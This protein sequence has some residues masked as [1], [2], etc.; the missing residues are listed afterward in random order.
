MI[1]M[2]ISRKELLI[3][4]W[5]VSMS[6]FIRTSAISLVVVVIFFYL[7]IGF[8]GYLGFIVIGLYG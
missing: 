4:L 7:I 2:E 6:K 5:F 8:C 1:V 3:M